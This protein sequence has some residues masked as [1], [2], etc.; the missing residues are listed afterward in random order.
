MKISIPVE[1][2]EVSQHFGHTPEFAIITVENGKIVSRETLKNPGHEPG[3]IPKLMSQNGVNVV[4][5]GGVGR[6]AVDLFDEMNITVI[7]GVSG[8]VEDAIQGYLAGK[9]VAG[10]NLCDH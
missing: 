9:L 5:T 2:G 6:K 8:T 7:S 1:G 4:I 10:K 3:L